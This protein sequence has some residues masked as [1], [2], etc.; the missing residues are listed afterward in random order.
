M[1]NRNDRQEPHE[2]SAIRG[3][4]KAMRKIA[5]TPKKEV[6]RRESAARWRRKKKEH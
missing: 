1:A 5:G 4:D 6:D 3:F 2:F